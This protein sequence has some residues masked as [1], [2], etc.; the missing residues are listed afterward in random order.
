M[1][2]NENGCSLYFNNKNK[3]EKKLNR[4]TD[5]AVAKAA[6]SIPKPAGK[7]SKNGIKNKFETKVMKARKK[8]KNVPTR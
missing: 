7:F 4:K 5:R 2:L 3:K 6:P 1:V 8:V